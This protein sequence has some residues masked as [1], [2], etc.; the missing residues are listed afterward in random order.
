MF[1]FLQNSFCAR[2]KSL[3]YELSKMRQRD[4]FY[5]EIVELNLKFHCANIIINTNPFCVNVT[6]RFICIYA[7]M[8]HC[9]SRSKMFTQFYVKFVRTEFYLDKCSSESHNSLLKRYGAME[10]HFWLQHNH[11]VFIVESH[12]FEIVDWGNCIP[13]WTFRFDITAIFGQTKCKLPWRCEYKNRDIPLFDIDLWTLNI[14]IN[15]TLSQNL[16]I[17]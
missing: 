16:R 2:W 14:G 6:A 17:V 9:C 15:L 8:W 10:T 13:F 4:R 12:T 3:D 1:A 7:L 11:V 5:V